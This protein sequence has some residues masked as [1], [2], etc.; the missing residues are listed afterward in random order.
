MKKLIIA[1]AAALMTAGFVSAQDLETATESYNNGAAQLNEGNKVE[2]LA[3]FKEALTMAQALGGDG[4]ELVANCKKVIPGLIL[5]I[6]KQFNN[7]KNFAGAVEKVS[8][9]I[10]VAKEY[11]DEETVAEAEALLPSLQVSEA[12][13]GAE[14]SLKAK[15]YAAAAAGYKK[16]LEIEPNN[17]NAALRLVQALAGTGNFAEAKEALAVAEANGKGADAAK[18]LSNAYA[19]KASASLKAKKYAEALADAEEASKI[20]ST[21][22]NAYLIAGQAASKIPNKTKLA[23]SNFEK[24][25]EA[26]PN[27]KN[28]GQIAYTV[29][30]LYQQ[31]QNKAKALEFYKKAE[32]SGYAQAA[33]M[34]KALSK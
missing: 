31:Q 33:E 29:G 17:G 25:L 28:A 24:Y 5:S 22:A 4:E 15:D 14:N 21:N 7:E 16:V 12:F 19:S 18:A 13:F 11:G 23:I 1:L 8:E 30:A 34:I 26:A 6:G 9:A 20:L 10:A 27:A 2:A 3:S 32:A